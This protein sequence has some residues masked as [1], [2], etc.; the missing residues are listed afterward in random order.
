MPTATLGKAYRI[1]LLLQNAPERVALRSANRAFRIGF[2]W[3]RKSSTE[4][5]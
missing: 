5:T 4:K 1:Q 2:N 3:G